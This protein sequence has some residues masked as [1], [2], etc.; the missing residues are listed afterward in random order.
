[1]A[2][3]YLQGSVCDANG[4]KLERRPEMERE[5]G[6][7]RV[8]ASRGVDQ[9]YFGSLRQCADRRFQQWTLAQGK[10]PRLISMSGAAPDDDARHDASID[11]ERR[12]GPAGLAGHAA[13]APA[14]R[15]A[16]ETA[17]NRE[18]VRRGMPGWRSC[19]SQL[20]LDEAQFLRR[21]RP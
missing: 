4:G 18:G 21:R 13:S 19:G 3:R 1:V 16:D 12:A 20:L 10:E 8:V 5:P 6:A 17:T 7:A 9:Q 2:A 11:R 15:E 14:P